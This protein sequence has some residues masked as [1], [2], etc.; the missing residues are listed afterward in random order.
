MMENFIKVRLADKEGL[1]GERA[2][3]YAI[4][5]NVHDYTPSNLYLILD[6]NTEYFGAGTELILQEDGYNV[7]MEATRELAKARAIIDKYHGWTA[8]DTMTAKVAKMCLKRQ[9]YSQFVGETIEVKSGKYLLESIYQDDDLGVG[10]NGV[11]LEDGTTKRFNDIE[12]LKKKIA[13]SEEMISGI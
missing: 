11:H 4:R 9:A 12:F 6:N 7:D 13:E 1:N 5:K 10:L 2:W 3:A 8:E